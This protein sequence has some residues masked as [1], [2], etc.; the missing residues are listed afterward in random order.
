M[1]VLGL[2]CVGCGSPLLG[3]GRES[4]ETDSMSFLIPIGSQKGHRPIYA[5]TLVESV[6]DFSWI[7]IV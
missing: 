6:V 1:F 5:L 3:A 4:L 2:Y 7:D